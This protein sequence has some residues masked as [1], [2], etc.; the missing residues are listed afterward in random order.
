MKK[1]LEDKF[2]Q[3]HSFKTKINKNSQKINTTTKTEED[4][5]N[6]LIL[7]T[8]F[9]SNERKEKII[10]IKKYLNEYNIVKHW[11]KVNPK[12]VSDRLY[13]IG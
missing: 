12:K 10:W 7:P 2:T 11:H 8:I 9:E 3:I 1:E 5:Y 4:R 6:R 13:N